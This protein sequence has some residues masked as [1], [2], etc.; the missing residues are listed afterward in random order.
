MPI[1]GV[2]V[3]DWETSIDVEGVL[4]GL[5]LLWGPS[6]LSSSTSESH[7]PLSRLQGF[8]TPQEVRKQIDDV[9][10]VLLIS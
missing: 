2:A 10:L 8:E 9:E 7:Q 6:E 3:V 1:Q 5:I 4:L